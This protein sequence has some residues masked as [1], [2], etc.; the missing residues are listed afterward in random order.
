MIAG[1]LPFKGDYD[2]AIVYS[3]VNEEPEPV[4]GLRTGVPLELEHIINKALAKNP[5]ERYQHIDEILVDLRTIT[6]ESLIKIK[7]EDEVSTS[8]DNKRDKEKP[9]Q[10]AKSKRRKMFL[11]I[12]NMATI[13][14]LTAIFFIIQK[15]G[16]KFIENRIIVIPFENKTGDVSQDMLGQMAAEMITQGM[17]QIR[18]IEVVPF[19]SEKEG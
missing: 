1:Q 6:K 8:E 13:V 15:Q 9:R 4:S 7:S 11:L 16:S 18:D 17:S 2:Q 5:N 3:I 10:Y 12:I 19:I 14:L